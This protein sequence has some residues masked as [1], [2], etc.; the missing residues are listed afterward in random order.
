MI[1]DLRRL[2]Q[3]YSG[4]EVTHFSQDVNMMYDF[5]QHKQVSLSQPWA[6]LVRI[7]KQFHWRSSGLKSGVP[8]L[9]GRSSNS[10]NWNASVIG[11]RPGESKGEYFFGD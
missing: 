5:A 7:A 11:I 9:R 10:A 1:S 8:D 3:Y 4:V 2:G 6:L